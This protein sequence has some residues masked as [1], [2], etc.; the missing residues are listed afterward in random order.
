[1]KTLSLLGL[2]SVVAI[3][4]CAVSQVKSPPARDAATAPAPATKAL[5]KKFVA[6][7]QSW[8]QSQIG[9]Q[10][11]ER[12]DK[13]A[14]PIL[15]P[16]LRAPARELRINA[17]RVLAGLG[18]DAGLFA[19]IAELG[20]KSPRP[21]TRLADNGRNFDVQGQ[22][23]RDR[24]SAAQTLAVIG[25]K[26]ARPAL[27]KALLDPDINYQ[28]AIT[29]GNLGDRAAIPALRR[30]LQR[31]QSVTRTSPNTDMKLW[32]AYGLLALDDARGSDVVSDIMLHDPSWVTRR[33]AAQALTQWGDTRDVPALIRATKDA[34]LEVRVNAI[35]ALG[36]IGDAR[37]LPALRSLAR[38]K[39]PAQAAARVGFGMVFS[40][41]SKFDFERVS[42]A[43]AA[44]QAIQRINAKK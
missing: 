28:A 2:F 21:T 37:A 29:L 3:A 20:D 15:L 23:V 4:G 40:E 42:V 27:E 14:I 30:T 9:E 33:H 43:Q 19:V 24:Y 6:A 16:L 36:R 25:D 32:A 38:D 5:L 13:A 41:Q 8:R 44:T 31:A 39:N 7:P 11:V 18:D 35:T 34:Q 22:I 12:N 17:G 1:M 10:L 26:R